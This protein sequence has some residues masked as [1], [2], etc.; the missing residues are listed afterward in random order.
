MLKGLAADWFY[1]LESGSIT[2]FVTL[3]ERFLECFASSLRIFLECFASS[4]RIKHTLMELFGMQQR[5]KESLCHWYERFVKV[6]A[7]VDD[8]TSKE[9]MAAFQRG[10]HDDEFVKNMI[11]DPPS[12]F[13]DLAERTQRFIAIE[14]ADWRRKKVKRKDI[15]GRHEDRSPHDKR[16]KFT[17][18]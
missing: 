18:C 10:L 8:L 17:P 6:A 1:S 16:E 2:S 7:E 13:T 5:E 9:K 15:S 14:E 11:I 3:K 4:L 12:D